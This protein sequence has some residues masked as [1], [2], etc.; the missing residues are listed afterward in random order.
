M[1]LFELAVTRLFSVLFFYHFSFFAISLVMSGL[2]IGGIWSAR[3]SVREMNERA[4]RSRLAAL[5]WM[6]SAAML[7]ALFTTLALPP[8]GATP[9]LSAVALQALIFLPGLVAAG[10]FLAAA[11]ARDKAWIG[12]L[13]ASD[14]IAAACACIAAIALMRIVQ[15]PAVLLAPSLFAA[16]AGVVVAPP[17]SRHRTA[18]ALIG[19]AAGV[20]LIVNAVAGGYLLHLASAGKE[21]PLI[22][23]GNE[24]SRIQVVD[25]GT[26]G[27]YI[28]IDKSAATV[29]KPAPT[30]ADGQPPRP[31]AWWKTGPQYTVY[32]V[33]RPIDR[34][35]IVGVGGGRDLLPPLAYGAAQV[36][37]YELNG[38]LVDLLQREFVAYNAT[39]TR[40]EVA[41]IHDE[42][43]VGIARSGKSYDVIRRVRAF[44]ERSVHARRMEDVPLAA[45][46]SRRAHH[47]AVVRA[48][49][50][51]RDP[52]A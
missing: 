32:R 8:A 21:R 12:T 31:Q 25:G 40:P 38:I 39:V 14:L 4:Y 35:A 33:G 51:G 15:G 52:A 28:I 27:R 45:L 37:G 7:A 5:G 24:Y 41:L 26:D 44:G 36:D 17:R 47:D 20:V 49:R 11:F 16:L 2:V 29:M 23:R 43:R 19:A 3:W 18:S 6:F 10:A 46:R 13:Y 48:G 30:E 34:V 1:L 9:S 50:T 22:E 42:A